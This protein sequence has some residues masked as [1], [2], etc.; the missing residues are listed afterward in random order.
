MPGAPLITV[1]T[2]C[3]NAAGFIRH[4]IESVLSQDFEEIEY[5]ILDG[6]STDGTP[7][8]AREYGDRVVVVSEPDNGTASAINRGFRKAR[9][10]VIAWLNADDTYLPGAVSSAMRALHSDPEAAAVYGNAYWTDE[11]G[12]ILRPYPVHPSAPE[13]LHKECLICQPACFMRTSAVREIDYLDE[14]LR[15]SFDYEL[16]MR[17]RQKGHFVFVP[18]FWATSRMHSANK[19]L[20]QRAGVLQ[21]SIAVLMRH[22]EYVPATWIY[23]YESYLR[24]RRDQFYEPTSTSYA[25][26]LRAFPTGW[27]INRRHPWRYTL[28]WAAMFTRI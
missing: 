14:Q 26:Y 12:Q 23:G 28:E 3:L 18:E 15:Y 5:L 27:K 11:S 2:P 22:F 17:L 24:D 20:G 1:V 8:I 7:E 19:T 21:E 16:W 6:G 9:G 4:T 10:S 25:A 13:L